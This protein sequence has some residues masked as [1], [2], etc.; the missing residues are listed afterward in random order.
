MEKRGDI[1]VAYTPDLKK[2]PD[3]PRRTESELADQDLIAKTAGLI[4]VNQ[5][6]KQKRD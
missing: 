4:N 3:E 1:N 2:R 6:A 5:P